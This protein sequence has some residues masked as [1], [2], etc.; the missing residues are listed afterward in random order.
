MRCLLSYHVDV[1]FVLQ[2]IVID[3]LKSSWSCARTRF[4]VALVV[5][6][7]RWAYSDKQDVCD[8]VGAHKNKESKQTRGKTMVWSTR[9]RTPPALYNILRT[10]TIVIQ[11]GTAVSRDNLDLYMKLVGCTIR[12]VSWNRGSKESLKNTQAWILLYFENRKK[13]AYLL[14]CEKCMK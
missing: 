8:Q 10:C 5:W 2:S 7:D 6:Y 13:S 9:K 1:I 4:D 11:R 3:Y 14:F 12:A